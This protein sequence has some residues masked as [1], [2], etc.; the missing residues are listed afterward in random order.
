MKKRLR[1]LDKDSQLTTQIKQ[2]RFELMVKTVWNALVKTDLT[3]NV[4][5]RPVQFALVRAKLSRTKN[6][7]YLL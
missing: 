4:V 7:Q 2:T 6:Q 1:E 5:E 3:E